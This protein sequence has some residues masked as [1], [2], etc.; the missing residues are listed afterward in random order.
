MDNTS[1]ANNMQSFIKNQYHI[2]LNKMVLLKGKTEHFLMQLEA[3]YQ[4]A[5]CTT[6]VWKMQWQQRAI[7]K[8]ELL[9]MLYKELYQIS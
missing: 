9:T 8:I 3:C 5:K 6:N 2:P 4:L 1:K 7:C